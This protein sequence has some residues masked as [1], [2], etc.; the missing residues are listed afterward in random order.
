MSSSLSTHPSQR[1]STSTARKCRLL[2]VMRLLLECSMLL[3]LCGQIVTPAAVTMQN[4]PGAVRQPAGALQQHWRLAHPREHQPGRAVR[5]VSQLA[6][7]AAAHASDDGPPRLPHQQLAVR[8]RAVYA[9]ALQA[10]AL[11]HRLTHGLE[12][13]RPLSAAEPCVTCTSVTPPPPRYASPSLPWIPAGSHSSPPP[14]LAVPA[15]STRSS[16]RR[17]GAGS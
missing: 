11:P 6:R 2:P 13:Y 8:R 10:N 15:R 7:H 5:A 12:E 17:P 16:G 9:L 3:C 4:G 1:R 14:C